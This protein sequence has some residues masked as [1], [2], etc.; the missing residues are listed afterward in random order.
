[1]PNIEDIIDRNA[2]ARFFS[3]I[4]STSG[5]F[6]IAIEEDDKEKI[7]FSWK[8]GLYEFNKRPLNCV[9]VQLLTRELP[10]RFL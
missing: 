1:M 7:A 10:I 6:Q 2:G 5:Y 8:N 3:K 9:T 4:D